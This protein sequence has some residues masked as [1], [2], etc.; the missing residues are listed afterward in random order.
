MP[1][2]PA[3]NMAGI[4]SKAV[5]PTTLDGT[6]SFT[7]NPSRNPILI[8]RNN[9]GGAL[10]PVLVGATIVNPDIRNIGE[11]DLSSGYS[12]PE[13]ADGTER[14]IVLNDHGLYLAGASVNV[15]GATGMTAVLMEG[16]SRG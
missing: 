11:I 10:T 16:T 13:M 8:L 3:T 7:Y 12:F 2:I 15:N 14:A 4:D 1:A 6:D 9:T 5:T